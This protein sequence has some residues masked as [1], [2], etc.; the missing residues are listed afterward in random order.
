[1][2]LYPVQPVER[3]ALVTA[4]TLNP[5]P[6]RSI[7]RIAGPAIVANTS[8]PM[9]SLVDTWAIGHLPDPA[10]LGAISLGGFVFSFIYWS[11]G[12]LRMGT[13]GLVAQA[14]GSGKDDRVERVV[15]RSMVLGVAIAVLVLAAQRPLLALSFAVFAPGDALAGHVEEYV[16][17][18]IWAVPAAL[19]KIAVVGFLIGTQ[20]ARTALMLELVLNVT[21]AALDL[22]FVVGF[23]WGVAGVAAGSV[24]AE[25]LAAGVAVAVLVRLLGAGRIR[26][27]L[28]QARFWR[29]EEF[30]RLLSVNAFLFVRTLFL[31]AAF[32][33]VYRTGT[34][35]GA[36]TLAANHVLLTFTTL[37]ALGLDG[38][39]YAAEA[40]VGQ[41]VGQASRR[42]FD[43]MVV[44]STAWAAALSLA[45]AA[46]FAL[47]GEAIIAGLTDQL[48]VRAAAGQQ[49]ALVAILPVVAVWSYQLDGIFI[50]ATRT[51]EMMWTM[52]ISFALFALLVA[53][54][55]PTGGNRGLWTAFVVFFALRGVGLGLCYPLIVRSIPVNPRERRAL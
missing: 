52:M 42:R 33:L 24:I 30:A 4:R 22:L 18:R 27:V 8:G 1:M 14:Y 38:L 20:R 31:L 45:Y 54:L 53:W 37:I 41:A 19:V 11:L 32:A 21:N 39:A 2:P 6:H 25:W 28:G 16:V 5:H 55:V 23:G 3:S 9:V 46:V 51:A 36:V 35:L 7:W 43:Q 15:L 17:I 13:T 40:L 50:G 49:I 10:L 47:W 48:P 44:L 29:V 26:A 12:F 34:Q